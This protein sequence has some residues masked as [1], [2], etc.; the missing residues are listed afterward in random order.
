[1][2]SQIKKQNP[3][4]FFLP[5][6]SIDQIFHIF[7]VSPVNNKISKSSCKPPIASSGKG[8][9]CKGDLRAKIQLYK[10]HIFSKKHIQEGLMT[11]GESQEKIMDSLHDIILFLDKKGLLEEGSNLIKTSINGV[12]N[13][14]IRCFIENGEAI[15][16]NAYISDFGRIY[17]NFI[18]MT[19]I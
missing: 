1:L 7:C 16:V 14:E 2:I 15:G 9:I 3:F 5:I 10:E 6:P 4:C 17:G 19:K 13:I 11:A 12:N 18:D 8:I